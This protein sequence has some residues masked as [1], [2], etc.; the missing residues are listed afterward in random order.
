MFLLNLLMKLVDIISS[1]YQRTLQTYLMMTTSA[2]I[3]EAA[4]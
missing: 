1:Q 2:A 3:A 4:L